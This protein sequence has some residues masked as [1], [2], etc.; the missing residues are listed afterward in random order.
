MKKIVRG[1][2]FTLRIPVKKIVNGEQVS[3][4]LTDCTDIAVHVV[5]QYKRTA[6]PYTIDK[7]SNDVLLADVDGTTLSLGTYALEVTGVSEG[8]NW[9]SYEYEQFAIVDNNA[10]SDTIFEGG[11]TDGNTSIEDG[12]G[13]NA[14]KGCMD[15]KIEGFAVDTALVVL[16]PV[17]SRATIIELIANADA[18]IA[19]VRETEAAVKA[20]EDVRVES[21]TLRQSAEEQ[22][23]ENEATRQTAETQRTESEMERVANEEAR[24]ANE[25]ARVAAEEQRA[26]TFTELSAAANAAVGKA[27]EAIKAVDAAIE[28]ANTAENER[29]EAERQRAEAEATRSREEGIRQESE[30]ERVRQ[31]T[32]RETAEATRQNAEVER[33]KADVEREKRV[34]EAISNTSSAAKTAADAAAVAMET[35]KQ[36]MNVITEAERVNAELKGNV[37]T[38]TDRTG[39]VKTLDL[40]DQEEA[41]N[42]KADIA[43]IKESMGI[44]SDK[45]NITLTAKENN[46]AISADGVKVSKQGWAIAEFTAELGNI[47]LFNPGKTSSDVCVFAEYIDK[48]ET[49]AIDYAY[50]YDESGRVLTAKATY[51]G[52]TY[53][54]TYDYSSSITTITDQD[55]NNVSSLPGVYTTTV[56]AYQ[57]MTILNANA[58]LPED[59]YCRFVSNFTTASAI[60]IVVSYKF[61]SA[62][63]TMKVVR[64]GSTANMCS[65]LAKINKK[66]DE[67]SEKVS[68][69]RNNLSIR[70][71]AY[72]TVIVVDGK[73][74]TLDGK[75][76]YSFPDFHTYQIEKNKLYIIRI[77]IDIFSRQVADFSYNFNGFWSLSSL[78]VKCWDTSNV[79]DITNM[80]GDDSSLNHLDVSG[81]DTSKITGMAGFCQNA[82]VTELDV[83]GWD[84]SKVI[85]LR[86][87]AANSKITSLDVSGW[88]TSN[89]TDIANF[90]GGTKI[91][92]LDVSGWDTSKVTDMTNFCQNASVLTTLTFGEDFGKM[93]DKCGTLNLSTLSAW[94]NN[95]VKSL[96]TLYD[97]KANGMGVITIK[98]HANAKAKLGEDGI[99]LLTA[100]GYTIA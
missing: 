56:G 51:N 36:G 41:S 12:N 69:R 84:T 38:V 2:D 50:M 45:P 8:A 4:P 98:L 18:A 67:V 61:S 73:K 30:T 82:S 75:K 57:P 79:A 70:T 99:A 59:G 66:V 78:N 64:D 42:T 44:Y 100:K 52:K 11:T 85:S 22:R 3:F 13:D 48:V 94:K 27:D 32:A 21:E 87:F 5:S 17:S 72:G 62:D 29:A 96:L 20:S 63:L 68:N 76:T 92:S 23:A 24:K 74:Y 77:D 54:Y 65:Q 33:E 40:M 86:H 89:V 60:K 7:E 31:E 37:L 81:W 93:T 15:V 90:C 97:R 47:Y 88:D 49:R 34:S 55:G 91:T 19:A 14:N 71:K 83:S 58:E 28:K 53:T 6:L 9:R 43:R 95:S 39:E 35:A 16:P 25:E 26:T 10:S 46:V 80:F 1:N